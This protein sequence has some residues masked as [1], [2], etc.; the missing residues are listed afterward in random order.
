M[1]SPE[2]DLP[3]PGIDSAGRDSLADEMHRALDEDMRYDDD[4]WTRLADA[5]L[6]WARAWLSR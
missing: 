5:A 1:T 3:L 4:D 6:I 2:Q